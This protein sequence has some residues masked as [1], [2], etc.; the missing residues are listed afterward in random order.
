MITGATLMMSQS[1]TIF[2]NREAA[3]KIAATLADIPHK[4]VPDPKG[5]ER[6]IIAL[7]DEDDPS[8]FVMYL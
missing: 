5:S 3:E 7:Y 4:I 1:H 8:I 6:C 2:K